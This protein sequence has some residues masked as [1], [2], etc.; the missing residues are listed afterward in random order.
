MKKCVATAIMMSVL[1][2]GTSNAQKKGFI[3]SFVHSYVHH[4]PIEIPQLYIEG[5]LNPHVQIQRMQTSTIYNRK[6]PNNYDTLYFRPRPIKMADFVPVQK[7]EKTIIKTGTI[8]R[9]SKP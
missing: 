4:A 5:R 6:V 8:R 1:I 7:Q 9:K 2:V 3:K